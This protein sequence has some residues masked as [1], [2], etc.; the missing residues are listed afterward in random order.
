MEQAP[1]NSRE[2]NWTDFLSPDDVGLARMK[3][4]QNFLDDH[5][6]G[7]NK[8]RYIAGELPSQSFDNETFDLALYSHFL[9]WYTDQ[10]NEDFHRGT[11]QMMR[12]RPVSG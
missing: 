8:G 9:L 1:Q 4:M 5:D 10:L 6:V 3:A 2:F 11:N 7:R 12:V